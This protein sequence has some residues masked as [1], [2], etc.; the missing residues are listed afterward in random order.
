MVFD[1]CAS[2]L[3]IY[4]GKEMVWFAHASAPK[5]L[6]TSLT[7]VVRSLGASTRSHR[8]V[9]HVVRYLAETESTMSSPIVHPWFVLIPWI[10]GLCI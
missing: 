5:Q 10:A 2:M 7:P 4:E 9:R 3:G 1:I 8:C 6:Q